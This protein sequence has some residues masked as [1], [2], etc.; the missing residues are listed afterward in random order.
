[1]LNFIANNWV[2]LLLILVGTFALVTY[3]LQERKKRIE[4]ASLI[5]TQI[6]E[7]QD[8]IREMSTFI[9][10]GIL[11]ETAFYEMLPIM[12][13]NYWNKYRHYFIKQIDSKSYDSINNLYKY[14]TALQEQQTLL[15]N[16]QKN[17]F[18]VMQNTIT[19]IE[20]NL[21]I[22][23][24]NNQGKNNNVNNNFAIMIPN[25]YDLTINSN[26]FWNNYNKDK[27]TLKSIINQKAL[28]SYIPLQ[29]TISLQKIIQECSLLE[30]IGCNG[31]NKL[32]KI[33]E[34]KF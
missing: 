18:F 13:E 7:I 2:N 34:K 15:K 14:A 24:L 5:I 11:N 30:I 22:S 17:F 32:K 31:Y 25:H 6:D 12:D 27:D 28:T 29:I 10:N 33:S 9:V 3:I 4:A 23:G 16:L 21:I 1:M 19:N 8:S 20:G 26:I